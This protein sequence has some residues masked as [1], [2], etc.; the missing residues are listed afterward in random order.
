MSF[1]G[2]DCRPVSSNEELQAS[3]WK[4]LE[5]RFGRFNVAESFLRGGENTC[6]AGQTDIY[7]NDSDFH[8]EHSVVPGHYT[9]RDKINFWNLL[10]GT[11][12]QTPFFAAPGETIDILD[13]GCGRARGAVGLHAY[14]GGTTYPERGSNVTYTGIDIEPKE[15]VK[16]RLTQLRRPD[17]RFVTA[18]ATNL[19]P[20]VS[21]ML[22]E[23]RKEGFEVIVIRHQNASSKRPGVWTKIL[24]EAWARLKAGGLLIV[25]SYTCQEHEIMTDVMQDLG[26]MAYINGRNPY[27]E[28]PFKQTNSTGLLKRDNYV[29]LFYK[30]PS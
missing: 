8:R 12:P 29:S 14:F 9:T 6:V 4:S 22:P 1:N 23:V 7:Y 17:L 3:I 5:K 2:L 21:K 25:T 18:D 27:A 30:D 19:T 13:I 16:A 11:V 15:I 28:M 20:V 26:A 24:R 10:A